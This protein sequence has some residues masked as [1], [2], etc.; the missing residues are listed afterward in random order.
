MIEDNVP[1][2]HYAKMYGCGVQQGDLQYIW[3]AQR[4]GQVN[5]GDPNRPSTCF[6]VDP[7]EVISGKD[8]KQFAKVAKVIKVA[9]RFVK[10][11]R[12]VEIKLPE[13]NEQLELE[14]D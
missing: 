7:V 11:D 13:K 14:F 3:H 12:W 1:L 8:G 2:A 10:E 9:D 6:S 4:W 5:M